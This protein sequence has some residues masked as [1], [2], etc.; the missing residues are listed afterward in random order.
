MR[1]VFL[2]P[3]AICSAVALLA[4]AECLFAQQPPV[5]KND[6]IDVT[7]ISA[8][9]SRKQLTGIM[10]GSMRFSPADMAGLP[11]FLGVTD[12]FRT[13]RLMPG[14]Q[15]AGEMD[16][17]IYV[18]GGDPGQTRV[19]FDGANIYSPSHILSFFSVFNSDHISS[20][21][22]L[23]S[24]VPAS[25]GG[26]TSGVM[27]IESSDMLPGRFGGTLTAGLISSQGTLKI[28]LGRKA[29]V[30]LSG[31]GSYVNYILNGFSM[32]K[33]VEARPKYGFYDANLT[34]LFKPD[35]DNT[36]KLNGYLGQDRLN[37]SLIGFGIRGRLNWSNA[38]V[39]AGW[40]RSFDNGALM[41]TTASGS[42]YNNDIM[43]FQND[44]SM[45]LPSGI[46]DLSFKTLTKIPLGGSRLEVGGDYVFHNVDV[47]Y[48]LVHGM[49][50]DVSA[51]IPDPYGVHEFGAGADWS[52]WFD[53]PVTVNVGLRYSG[54]FSCGRFHSGVEPRISVVCD[55]R[56]GM[57]LR[58]SAMG[59][60]QYISTVSVSG[61]GLPT[62]FLMP[63]TENIHPQSSWSASLGFSHIFGKEMFE[64]SIEPYFSYLDNAL[65][66]DGQ[67]FDMINKRYVTEEH[68]ICGKGRNYGIE[69]MFKKNSGKV[70][71]WVGYTLSRSERSFPDIMQGKT[72]LSKH[73]RLHNLSVVAN[74]NP[75]KQ[76]TL[77]AVFVYATGTPYTPPS[78]LYLIGDSIV[79]EYGE[80]N[81]VRMPDYHRLDL[82]ATWDFRSGTRF[83]HSVNLS[84]YNVYARPNPLFRDIKPSYEEGST[85][86]DLKMVGVSVYSLV[87]SLSYTFKF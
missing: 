26:S 22:V 70:T 44:M 75:L 21:E 62:D 61:M 81:S 73:D 76:L 58:A 85:T 52:A 80:H 66:F 31:R 32:S 3:A 65:E 36:F 14:V 39:S 30:T 59:Q 1:T 56:D 45:L 38:A 16:S 5:E 18:R 63:V 82:S 4:S 20:A 47:Q 25:I 9:R 19:I 55:I 7:V 15:T 64:Y 86:L 87:P 68:V 10:E 84:V 51:E 50:E 2:R 27:K 46:G 79:Q 77:S 37:I 24:S 35:D 41:E 12:V 57:R 29:A 53:M 33:T 69:F 48:P 67:L 23:K 43:L 60:R 40:K 34:F 13:F 49:F 83:R 42:L 54:A 17:G 71:G 78:G 11:K 74:Y 28:P 72:F 8:E 6:S